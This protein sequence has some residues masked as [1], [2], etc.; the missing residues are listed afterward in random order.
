MHIKLYIEKGKDICTPILSDVHQ[1][2]EQ[3]VPKY[4]LTFILLSVLYPNIE[5]PVFQYWV[6][7]ILIVSVVYPNI[8]CSVSWY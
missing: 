3:C 4:W 5:C 8:E 7:C 6:Y 1:N 2:N